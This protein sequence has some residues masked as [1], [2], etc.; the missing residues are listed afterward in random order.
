MEY[1]K[2]RIFLTHSLHEKCVKN[3]RLLNISDARY[4]I[5]GYFLQ[6]VKNIQCY[7][8]SVSTVQSKSRFFD[9]GFYINRFVCRLGCEINWTKKQH[10]DCI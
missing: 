7:K 10:F 4:I 3:I 2:N 6:I 8:Y 9:I 5:T 1:S